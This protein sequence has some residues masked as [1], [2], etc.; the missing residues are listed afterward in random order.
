MLSSSGGKATRLCPAYAPAQLQGAT[1]P[2]SSLHFRCLSWAPELYCPNLPSPLGSCVP[3]Q[4][5]DPSI[6]FY[7]LSPDLVWFLNSLFCSVD[8]M[9]TG[10]SAEV[11]WAFCSPSPFAESLLRV[12]PCPFSPPSS[13][14]VLDSL[15]PVT[16]QPEASLLLSPLVSQP[17]LTVFSLPH[18]GSTLLSVHAEPCMPTPSHLPL[19]REGTATAKQDLFPA[20]HSVSSACQ[21]LLHL[22]IFKHS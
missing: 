18:R 22:G 10:P 6:L 2:I 12:S 4:I 3:C 8:L 13:Q 20:S 16:P 17:R 5:I 1:L 14:I 7:L 19:S 9:P 11:F 15:E 21:L